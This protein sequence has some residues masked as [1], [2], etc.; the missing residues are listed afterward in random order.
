MKVTV[1]GGGG[2]VGSCAAFVLREAGGANAVHRSDFAGAI[3]VT[4]E[5]ARGNRPWTASS[6][7]MSSSSSSH[8]NANPCK[9]SW[10]CSRSGC[11]A[12]AS[13]GYLAAGK[14]TRRLSSSS[15]QMRRSSTQ[16]RR[17]RTGA[18]ASWS[19]K[20]NIGVRQGLTMPLHQTP[21]GVQLG[22]AEAIIRRQRNR[23]LQPELSFFV[24]SLD[25]NVRRLPSFL[26]VEVESVRSLAQYRGHIASFAPSPVRSRPK[27]KSRAQ[28][29]ESAK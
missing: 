8:R 16:Q 4:V 23:R 13:R 1:I 26:A 7:Q 19:M 11:A 18:G 29:A 2:R 28:L 15:N 25:M 24:F 5:G 20:S 10:T 17:A 14:L 9:R 3:E 27:K 22:R 12:F 6:T 21:D